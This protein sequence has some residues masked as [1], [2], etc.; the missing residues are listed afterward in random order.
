MIRCDVSL[1]RNTGPC[2][3]YYMTVRVLE[4][5]L[6]PSHGS[7]SFVVRC[8]MALS[9]FLEIVI[10]RLFCAD[11]RVSVNMLSPCWNGVFPSVNRSVANLINLALIA[12]EC[13]MSWVVYDRW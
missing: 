6:C 13:M 3:G 12:G 1:P 10:A 8:L 4:L 2:P 7:T 5:V 9:L 11:D